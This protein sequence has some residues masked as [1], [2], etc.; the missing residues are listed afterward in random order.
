MRILFGLGPLGD[1]FIL[2]SP[3]PL[4]LFSLLSLFF[5]NCL[6]PW[7]WCVPWDTHVIWTTV[8]RASSPTCT[9]LKGSPFF[10]KRD[11]RLQS[12]QAMP[13]SN[14]CSLWCP[15][16]GNEL[17]VILQDFPHLHQ[18]LLGLHSWGFTNYFEFQGK[19]ANLDKDSENS[20]WIE[21]TDSQQ[22]LTVCSQSFY[23]P[24]FSC[25]R[26]PIITHLLVNNINLPP[27]TFVGERSNSHQGLSGGCGRESISL[28]LLAPRVHPHFI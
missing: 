14:D 20:C 5:L 9:V 19:G 15:E 3:Q 4:T 2:F 18:V 16:L 8:G 7:W 23:K 27:C 13:H 11:G 1:A 17:V 26:T 25:V 28:T 22:S 6:L 21:H 10:T 12:T 24:Q